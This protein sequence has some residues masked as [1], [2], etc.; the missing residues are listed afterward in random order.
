MKSKIRYALALTSSA[1]LTF[2]VLAAAGFS[3]TPA[4]ANI[5]GGTITAIIANI[6]TWLLGLV[7]FIG[8]IGFAIAGVLYLTAA[9]DEDRIAQAKKAMSYSIIGVIVAIVGV[10]ILKAAQTMLGGTGQF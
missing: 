10:V 1:V 6:M 9:G 3:P 5:P 8:V 4:G 7:G 2:P